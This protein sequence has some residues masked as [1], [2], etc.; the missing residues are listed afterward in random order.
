MLYSLNIII[1]CNTPI[2]RYGDVIA[3]YIS[4]AK[5][6]SHIYAKYQYMHELKYESTVVIYI[7]AR[8]A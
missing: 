2:P 8:I 3:M 5:I 7:L 4:R 1:I 6:P